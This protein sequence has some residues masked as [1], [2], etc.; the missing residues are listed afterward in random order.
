MEKYLNKS[1]N[2]SV[3]RYLVSEDNIIVEFDGGWSYEYPSYRIG[4]KNLSVMKK[5]ATDGQGLNT[6]INKNQ[7]VKKGFSRKFISR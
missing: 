1:G 3:T 2:S 5:L 7:V 6:F 4:D